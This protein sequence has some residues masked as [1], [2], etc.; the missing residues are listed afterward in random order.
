MC[1]HV[2]SEQS[3]NL[4]QRIPVALVDS[5]DKKTFIYQEEDLPSQFFSSPHDRHSAIPA[6]NIGREDILESPLH[7]YSATEAQSLFGGSQSASAS[8]SA[9]MHQIVEGVERLVDSDTYENPSVE[10]YSFLSPI[11]E[12]PTPTHASANRNSYPFGEQNSAPA[13]IN[14]APPPGLGPPVVNVA[15]PPR[16]PSAQ[17]YTSR[18]A[19]PSIPSIWNLGSD[20]ASPQTPPGLG[21]Q[22]QGAQQT[23]LPSSTAGNGML[24]ERSM[25]RDQLA[26]EILLRQHLL[27][28]T[29]FSNSM[30]VGSM[31]TPWTSSNMSPAQPPPTGNGWDHGRAT[32][33]GY[34]LPSQTSTGSMGHPSWAN[35]AFLASS[36]AGG[37]PYSSGLVGR[38][39]ATQLGAIGQTPPCGQGG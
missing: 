24:S 8:M 3:A 36:L 33:N 16:L 13:G 32:Y 28:Q 6:A 39:P 34:E 21:P 22:A 26:N 31:P 35:E 14:I 10:Q 38:K 4:M 29:Q 25:S 15:G 11:G 9:N 17:S 5:E 1:N 23:S 20:N 2:N 27:A 30:D 37:T 7:P 19:I 18:P 12:M